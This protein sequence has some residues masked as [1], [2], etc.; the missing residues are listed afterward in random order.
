MMKPTPRQTKLS[1]LASTKKLSGST[2]LSMKFDLPIKMNILASELSYVVFIMLINVKMPTIVG[3]LTFMSM[4]NVIISSVEHNKCLI[5]S[6]S[7]DTITAY[8]SQHN[9]EDGTQGHRNLP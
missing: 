9:A 8:Q 6:R 7:G 1:P 4:L 5:T 3:I 2:Q